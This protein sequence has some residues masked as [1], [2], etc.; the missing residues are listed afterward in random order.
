MK[1]IPLPKG[2][3]AQ[4][5]DEDYEHL[6]N[7][8]WN[9]NNGYAYRFEKVNGVKK[10]IMMHRNIMGFTNPIDF[11][12]HI[13][14]N[15]LNNQRLNLRKCDYSGNACNRTPQGA[16]RYLGVS[17]NRRTRNGELVNMGW[18]AKIKKNG[19][20]KHLG[21]FKTEEDAALAYNEAAM[22]IHGEFA[23]LNTL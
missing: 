4:V 16:S 9:L 23:N 22:A 2:N 15:K 13:D 17:M 7:F 3:F 11:V 21:V 8:K 18:C 10:Q 14:R 6:I 1:L 12:D 19:K 20:Q 5:D